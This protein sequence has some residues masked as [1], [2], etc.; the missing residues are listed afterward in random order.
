LIIGIDVAAR[1]KTLRGERRL[2]EDST[3]HR[4]NEC[5]ANRA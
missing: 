3:G 4:G 2:P 5:D 1:D